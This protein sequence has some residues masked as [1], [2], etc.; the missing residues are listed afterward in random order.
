MS[1]RRATVMVA[2]AVLIALACGLGLRQF[3]AGSAS[4]GFGEGADTGI[5]SAVQVR[6]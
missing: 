2:V 4:Q 5:V 1:R 3:L 6:W